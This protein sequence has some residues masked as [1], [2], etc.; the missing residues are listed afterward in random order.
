MNPFAVIPLR[1]FR[2]NYIWL[3][4]QDNFALVVDPGDAAPVLDYL[5]QQQLKLCAILLTHHHNDHIGG[6]NELLCHDAIPVYGP[7][8]P[9]DFS[10]TLVSEGEPVFIPQMA[11]HFNV[12]NVP[13]HTA[14]HLA[15]YAGNHLFCGDTLFGCGCGRIFDGS[16]EA[17][18]ASL[19]KIARL[20]DDTLV[21][22]AHE[23]T[24]DNVRFARGVDPDNRALLARE[25]ADL[26]RISL[27]EPTLPST[28]SLEKASNP[29]L[30]C[31][32]PA[33]IS[34]AIKA[35]CQD[36]HNPIETFRAIRTL[37]NNFHLPQKALP[38]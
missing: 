7:P 29:F 3:V 10:Y 37:K 11:L 8:M 30:R 19:Q 1:A 9:T 28:L 16:I 15:Y 20:P 25:Q 38:D 17:L 35:G 22:C 31:E 5:Q 26:S 12:L 4:V 33:I 23:Y 21:Y 36:A 14:Q 13:G 34:A 18:Y 24:L 27:G 2:D 6:V 32:T